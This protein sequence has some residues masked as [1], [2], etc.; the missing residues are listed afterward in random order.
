MPR[1]MVRNYL[2]L[3]PRQHRSTSSFLHTHHQ[4][5]QRSIHFHP[6]DCQFALPRRGQRRLVHQIFQ[7]RPRK[8]RR[9]SRYGIQVHVRLQRL[10]SRVH[11]Q[12]AR[13]APNVGKF[14]GHLPVEPPRTQQRLVQYVQP[15]RGR[16]RD[17][18]DVAVE[19]VHLHQYLIDGLFPLVVPA[20]VARPALSAHG[21]DF[22]EEYDAGSVLLG[23]EE[24]LP[25]PR[26]AHA[27]VQLDEFR[28][29][30]A[31]EWYFGLACHG[32][33]KECLTSTRR[34]IQQNP[35]RNNA[36]V[37]RITLRK[38]QKVHNLRQFQFRPIAP[39]HVL[40]GDIGIGMKVERGL[41]SRHGQRRGGG[42]A[43]PSEQEEEAGEYRERQE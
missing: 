31:D 28:S 16:Q 37:V 33:G 23:L 7:L 41:H 9:A 24:E 3:L 21:V 1:L 26:C 14:H 19:P 10:P 22:V 40:E 2:H 34:T 29:G 32:L 27:D 35:T 6:S 36:P 5:I 38:F 42:V 15:I 8:S 13:P 20:G 17:H 11:G 12:Y 39:C 4:S 18:A 25:Y 43:A 30:D